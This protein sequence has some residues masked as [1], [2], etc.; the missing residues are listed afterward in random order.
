MKCHEG[1]KE[2]WERHRTLL[3]GR[4][5][6][7]PPPRWPWPG[8]Y[9][10]WG[11][12]RETTIMTVMSY[13]AVSHTMISKRLSTRLSITH[14]KVNAS[15]SL[16]LCRITIATTKMFNLSINCS[17]LTI[18]LIIFIFGSNKE[19]QQRRRYCSTRPLS[20]MEWTQCDIGTITVW[21]QPFRGICLTGH[22]YHKA[23]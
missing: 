23:H 1:T 16:W 19:L 5:R 4:C 15:V 22:V 14:T 11:R 20:D 2:V 10:I 13:G 9:H 8:Q 18:I 17:S 21:C 6:V 12:C 7:T 3:P